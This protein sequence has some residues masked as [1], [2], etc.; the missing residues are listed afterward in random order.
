MRSSTVWRYRSGS[1][2]SS[3]ADSRDSITA[4]LGRAPP[5]HRVSPGQS[6][7]D[8]A[9][10]HIAM[11]ARLCLSLCLSIHS[12]AAASLVCVC[13]SKHYT[14]SLGLAFTRTEGLL[15]THYRCRALWAST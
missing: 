11:F 13:V 10:M 1:G 2:R 4:P 7:P 6:S 15:R 12:A 8:R 3:M 9:H 5:N 14:H